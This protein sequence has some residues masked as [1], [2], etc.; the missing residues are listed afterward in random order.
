MI[1]KAKNVYK[2]PEHDLEGESKIHA[3]LRLA[4]EFSTSGLETNFN[5]FDN[6]ITIEFETGYAHQLNRVA[7]L[8][9]TLDRLFEIEIH[10]PEEEA[11]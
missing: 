1:N 9:T 8:I 10:K 3:V 7:E 11:K 6:L 4:E 2:V 5:S